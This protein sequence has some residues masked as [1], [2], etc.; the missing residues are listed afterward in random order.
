M[1]NHLSLFFAPIFI[2]VLFTSCSSDDGSGSKEKIFDGYVELLYQEDINEFGANGYTQITGCLVIGDS[3]TS[4][5]IVDLS[6]LSSL[7][8]VGCLAI[9]SVTGLKTLHGLHNLTSVSNGSIKLYDLWNLED[10][11]ALQ[12]I[13]DT[14]ISELDIINLRSITDINVFNSIRTIGPSSTTIIPFRISGMDNLTSVSGLSNLETVDGGIIFAR[15]DVLDD[16]SFIKDVDFSKSFRL[17]SHP[18]LTE[19]PVFK[20]GVFS[21]VSLEVQYCPMLENLNGLQNQTSLGSS[22]YLRTTQIRG[23][24][25]L[26]DLQ[27]LEN[28]TRIVGNIV[29]EGNDALQNLD[30]LENLKNADDESFDFIDNP[31]LTDFCGLT[32][33]FINHGHGGPGGLRLFTSGNGYNPSEEDILDGNCSL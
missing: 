2:V 6:P 30:A 15:N 20:E 16:L 23:N 22:H 26:T 12:N 25:A 11:S 10:L 19:L 17:S 8:K 28:L 13:T 24:D 21:G 1:K 18:K 27:G 29:V 5:D 33:V 9:Y 14:T 7:N 31:Q 4:N 32:N 3:E